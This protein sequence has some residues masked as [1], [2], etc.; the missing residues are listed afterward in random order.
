M[1]DG[2]NPSVAVAQGQPSLRSL[3]ATSSGSLVAL[4]TPGGELIV[5][6]QCGAPELQRWA[7]ATVRAPAQ[8][9]APLGGEC[10]SCPSIDV[11]VLS[12]SLPLSWWFP[13]PQDGTLDHAATTAPHVPMGLI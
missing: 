13:P 6:Q 10:T 3:A 1:T 5:A 11:I 9:D 2:A 8:E 12:L 7:L 4:Y